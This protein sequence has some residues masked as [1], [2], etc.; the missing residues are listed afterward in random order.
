MRGCATSDRKFF[1]EGADILTRER[2]TLTVPESWTRRAFPSFFLFFVAGTP[3]RLPLFLVLDFL[4][5]SRYSRAPKPVQ[6]LLF[7]SGPS[8]L[9]P[10]ALLAWAI[11]SPALCG[12]SKKSVCTYG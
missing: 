9:T 11:S 4:D 8:G 10:A 2:Y 6:L 3:F 7:T 1:A 12:G 5:F